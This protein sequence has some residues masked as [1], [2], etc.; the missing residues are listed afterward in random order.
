M[1][2]LMVADLKGKTKME[3]LFL[4]IDVVADIATIITLIIV[5]IAL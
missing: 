3:I 1:F 2:F 5:I 4:I